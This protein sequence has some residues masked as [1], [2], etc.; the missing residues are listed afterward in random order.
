[1]ETN[2]LIK[3]YVRHINCVFCSAWCVTVDMII[4][5]PKQG[6]IREAPSTGKETR[7]LWQQVARPIALFLTRT[8]HAG[9]A[10]E[11]ATVQSE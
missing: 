2:G 1:M 4:G 6:S 3:V 9:P 8:P 11:K 5:V 7:T 10:L